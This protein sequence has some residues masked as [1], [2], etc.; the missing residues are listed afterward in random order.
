MREKAYGPVIHIYKC[1][2]LLCVDAGSIGGAPYGQSVML[3]YLSYNNVAQKKG[4]NLYLSQ[5]LK[6]TLPCI[7]V[8][9]FSVDL[10]LILYQTFETNTFVEVDH[11]F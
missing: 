3:P 11:L 1:E 9:Q 5:T 6:G 10:P 2:I 8:F 4:W 7:G